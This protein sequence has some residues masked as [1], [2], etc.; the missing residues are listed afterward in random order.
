MNINKLLTAASLL[1]LS[2]L[3]ADVKISDPEATYAA[4]PKIEA[5]KELQQHIDLGFAN[6]TGNTETLNLN[7][8]YGM[9]FITTG[10]EGRDLKTSFDASAYITENSGVRDNE[11][12]KAYLGLEQSFANEWLGYGFVSWLRNT[13]RNYD[14]KTLI[15]AGIGKKLIDDG[16]Q[17]LKVKLGG[18]YNIEE[19]SDGQPN[20]EFGS[21]TEY[22]EYRYKFNAVSEGYVKLGAMQNVENFSEDYE[23][24]AVA[25][26]NFAVAERITLTL[27]GEVDYDNLPA[28]GFKKTD[29]KTIA[30][31]GYHF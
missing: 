22:M 20:R 1:T 3:Y 27:E 17:L 11:E 9:S 16:T 5:S 28:V 8:K 15:G 31:V 25:G 21:V 6:T 30:R 18:A 19:F 10:Y 23:L 14:S 24:M 13:F 4:A 7:A 2:S 29:T 12:Y 26:F